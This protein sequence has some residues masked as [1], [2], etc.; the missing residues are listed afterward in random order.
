MTA[1][2]SVIAYIIGIS[3][4]TFLAEGDIAMPP[5]L[6]PLVKFQSTPSSRK[7]TSISNSIRSR[8]HISIHTF[9][10]EGDG[11]AGMKLR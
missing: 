9:L 1:G 4:H 2:A 7:V 6:E 3:I 11:R 10:A 8:D 5:F